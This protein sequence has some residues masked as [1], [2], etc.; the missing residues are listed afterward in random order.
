MRWRCL[1]NSGSVS[2]PPHLQTT[3]TF[4]FVRVC[5]SSFLEVSVSVC[6]HVCLRLYM[7][8]LY[9]Q[10][11]CV[12][13]FG[14]Y[15]L[16]LFSLGVSFRSRKCTFGSGGG[17]RHAQSDHICSNTRDPQSHTGHMCWCV[18]VCRV[19]LCYRSRSLCVQFI[20]R[21]NLLLNITRFHNK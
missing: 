18:H 15:R 20:K 1:E 14:G 16:R 11:L 5:E 21:F 7:V 13:V 6:F 19:R 4:C 12:H 3:H 17:S 8:T 9:A 2:L 10:C